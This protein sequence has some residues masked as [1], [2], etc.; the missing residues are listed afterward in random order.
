MK[1]F[2]VLAVVCIAAAF[3]VLEAPVHAHAQVNAQ[4]QFEQHPTADPALPGSVKIDTNWAYTGAK[5]TGPGLAAPRTLNAVQAAT[6]VQSWLAPAIFG[7]PTIGNPPPTLPVYRVD[8][9]G[10]WGSTDKRTLPI[11]Y[12]SQGDAVWISFPVTIETGPASTPTTT[13]TPTQ[14]F[15]PPD[16]PQV[17]HAFEGT[18][19]LISTAGTAPAQITPATTVPAPSDTGKKSSSSATGWII[20]LAIVGILL[21]AVVVMRVAGGRS[22]PKPKTP[23]P[24]VKVGASP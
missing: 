11:F 15:L 7:K 23:K 13:P 6:F 10:L 20:V 14:W 4:T 16:A 18:A 22:K 2:R 9:T 21:V 19:K 24:D 12:A 3:V 8:V 17:K 5:I 1:L